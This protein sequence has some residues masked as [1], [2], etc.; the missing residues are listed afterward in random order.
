[1]ST[2]RRS[3]RPDTGASCRRGDRAALEAGED[4]DVLLILEGELVDFACPEIQEPAFDRYDAAVVARPTGR[5]MT[6][7]SRPSNRF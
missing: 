7:A 5:A 4:R 1:M 3:A 6:L 2:M